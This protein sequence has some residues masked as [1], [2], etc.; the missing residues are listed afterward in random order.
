MR[1]CGGLTIRHS[2]R[3][4]R[5][6]QSGR[7]VDLRTFRR[8]LSDRTGDGRRRKIVSRESRKSSCH[9]QP[10]RLI[11]TTAAG[12][13]AAWGTSKVVLAS[14][15]ANDPTPNTFHDKRV[16]QPS[17]GSGIHSDCSTY[18]RENHYPIF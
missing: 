16:L 5:D 18:L 7:A 8:P 4:G 13:V 6:P 12:V 2:T 3:E 17:E 15:N 11:D 1:A 9:Y 10:V 14:S